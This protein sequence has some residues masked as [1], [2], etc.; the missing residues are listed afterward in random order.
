V[1]C[2]KCGYIGFETV[3]RC[4]NCGYEFALAVREEE[5]AALPV[6]S[7]APSDGPLADLVL[8]SAPLP[9]DRPRSSGSHELD[10]D[11]VIG[12]PDAEADLPLFG[13]GQ[14]PATIPAARRTMER[15]PVASAAVPRRPLSVRRTTPDSS[16]FRTAVTEAAPRPVRNLELPLPSEPD[17]VPE[18][19]TTPEHAEAGPRLLAALTDTGL[20]LAIDAAVI[21]FT[22]RLCALT[23][24]ELDVLPWLPLAAFFLLLNGGYLLAFTAAT[25]QTIG[26]MAFG[27]R[28][29]ALDGP[30]TVVT[31][32]IRSGGCLLSAL[33]L[34]AGF[35]P[36]LFG[37]RSLEDRIARTAVVHVRE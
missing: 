15:H 8:T 10:L 9:V 36:A 2:S 18:R 22:L 24:R 33:T 4:R 19:V 13:E 28:I 27:L 14:G 5:P 35:V 37:G 17:A 31:A 1:K 30:V 11:R 20:L 34:G 29:V 26:K 3:D 16:R 25:G 21:Y 6:R 7:P 12:A 23:A 32:A